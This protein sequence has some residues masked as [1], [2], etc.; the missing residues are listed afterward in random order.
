METCEM[1]L[2][3]EYREFTKSREK[4]VYAAATEAS[5]TIFRDARGFAGLNGK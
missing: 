1:G 3:H 2:S 5:C 4:V